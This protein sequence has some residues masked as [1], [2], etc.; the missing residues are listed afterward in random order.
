MS[1]PKFEVTREGPNSLR[2]AV[3]GRI[4]AAMMEV[5]LQQM[6]TEM[7][8]MAH[9]DV[10]MIDEGAEWPTLGAIG[11][12]L[13]H[14]PQMIAMLHQLDRAALVSHNQ[15]FR[16]AATLESALIPGYEI[17]NFNDEASARAWLATDAGADT[18]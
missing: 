3:S 7:E 15:L 8:G 14:W 12:E 5:A 9:G 2:I 13:R 1:D 11:V 10:L 6:S 4:D 18:A 16:S 17:R